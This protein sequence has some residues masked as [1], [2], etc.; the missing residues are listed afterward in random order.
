MSDPQKWLDNYVLSV[1]FPGVSG[2]E[3]VEMLQVRSHL[4][5]IESSLGMAERTALESALLLVGTAARDDATAQ[6]WQIIPS[7]KWGITLSQATQ[8][9]H[10]GPMAKD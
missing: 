6:P 7:S 2:F 8:T 9:G 4:A 10:E 3:I 5:Q 1:K